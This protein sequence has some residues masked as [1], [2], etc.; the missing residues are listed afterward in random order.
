MFVLGMLFPFC[1]A[2]LSAK[3][4]SGEGRLSAVAAFPQVLIPLLKG[5]NAVFLLLFSKVD[6]S[7]SV[8]GMHTWK[9]GHTREGGS[10]CTE[11]LGSC[12]LN[13]TLV[14]APSCSES[15]KS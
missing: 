15:L 12:A 14:I 11:S 6:A 7:C 9:W 3:R 10:Y 4:A 8:Q 2:L 13:L 5:E 1:S